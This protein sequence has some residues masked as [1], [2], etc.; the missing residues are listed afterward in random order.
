MIR[1]PPRST[2]DRSSAASDVYKRQGCDTTVTIQLVF[3]PIRSAYISYVGCVG[4]DYEVVVNGT[5]YNSS[6]PQGT[7]ILT[8]QNGC[9][10]IITIALNFLTATQHDIQY[11]G[12]V[13]DNYSIIVNGTIYSESNPT[14]MELL[15]GSN[16]CDSVVTVNMVFGNQFVVNENYAGCEGDGYSVVVNGTTYDEFNPIGTEVFPGGGGCD[17]TVQI[18]LV[19]NPITSGDETYN[20]CEGDGYFVVVNGT[21]YDEGTST[22]METLTGSNGCD[23]IVTINLMFSPVLE[24]EELYIGCVGDGYSVVVNGTIY[25]E[26]NPDG[27]EV[28]TG[29]G[30]DSVVT[31]DLE[32]APFMPADIT[33]A[34]PFCTEAG[35]QTLTASP[36]GGTWSGSVS[37]DQ[38]D[39]ALLGPGT[40]EVIYTTPA[41]PCQSADT[42]D[43]VVYELSLIHI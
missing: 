15:T 31:I 41:G 9:D 40:H 38:F 19:F 2:L 36:A 5:L 26:N 42:I 6:N 12:C 27:I 35:I 16:G 22:G 30:C 25:D 3:R 28:I 29:A 8:A 17:S 23:S 20:G 10:S 7:E 24:G 14:G 32:F 21:T 39:P 37:S 4:D 1:R 13:G 34:G 18:N 43:I 11:T 33:V